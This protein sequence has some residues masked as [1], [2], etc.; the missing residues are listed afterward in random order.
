MPT[1]L[2]ESK[3]STGADLPPSFYDGTHLDWEAFRQHVLGPH[4][5]R[6]VSSAPKDKM[7]SSLFAMIEAAMPGASKF[8]EL[9]NAFQKQVQVGRGFGPSPLFPPNLLPPSFDEPNLARCMIPCFSR[10]TLPARIVN[11]TGPFYELS[12]PRSGL[13]CGFSVSALTKDELNIL[14]AWMVTTGTTVHFDSGYVSP[15][16]AVYCPF[17]IFE[18]AYGDMERRL[19]VAN[20]QCATGGACCVKALQMLYSKAWT[21]PTMP[22]P[23]IAFSCVIENTFAVVNMHW[24]DH[25]QSYCMAP[26]CKFDLTNHEHFVHFLVWIDSIGKWALGHLLPLVKTALGRLQQLDSPPPTP[27]APRLTLNTTDSSNEAIIKCLQTTFDG[28]PWRFEDDEFTPVSSSTASWGSPLMIETNFF[29][30]AIQLR[31]PGRTPTSAGPRKQFLPQLGQLPTPP[32]AYAQSPDL[33]W[34]KRL[35]HAMDEIRDLQKQLEDLRNDVKCSNDSIQVD[36]S[37][38]KTTLQS[39]LR[40][41][42]L[43][44]RHRAGSLGVQE[45]WLS[46]TLSRSPLI[47]EIRPS[48]TVEKQGPPQDGSDKSGS[49]LPEPLSPGLPSPGLISPGLASPTFSVFSE[50][51]MVMIPPAPPKSASFLKFVGAMATGHFIGALIPNMLIRIFVLGC[52]T[53]VCML[54]FAS[55]HLPSSAEYLFSLWRSPR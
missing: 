33:V 7:P 55:P 6:V 47:N 21:G 34:Q 5:I 40:K 53:D 39:V 27:K 32:P 9:K 18:R 8:D 38:I 19:Q 37:G 16:A 51:N 13:G 35:T 30:Q 2:V 10:E 20:N 52:I 28:I 54:A 46:Q 1:M 17:L 22:Q 48:D 23:P 45:A 41:E 29:N 26:L 31:H 49:L 4:R 42:T 24:I 12:I 36:L 43:T 44:V 50:S 25:G 11:Q 3:P 14:P 15:G